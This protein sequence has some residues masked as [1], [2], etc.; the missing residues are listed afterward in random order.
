LLLFTTQDGRNC[1]Y[2][3]YSFV[4]NTSVYNVHPQ[5]KSLKRRSNDAKLDRLKTLTQLGIIECQIRASDWLKPKY[6][7]VYIFIWPVS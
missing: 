5:T 2:F 7:N 3:S 1:L 6:V 4:I